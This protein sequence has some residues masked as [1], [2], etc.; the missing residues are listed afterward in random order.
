M[1]LVFIGPPGA[2]KGTQAQRLTA[3][4]AIPHVSTGDMLREARSQQTPLGQLAEK[5][6]S[7][8]EL[9]PDDVIIQLVRER[10]SRPDC[11]RGVL[12]D[13]FPRTLAQAQGL[14]ADLAQTGTPIDR[15]I[16]LAASDDELFRRLTSRGRADDNPDV[17]RQRLASYHRDTRPL[18]DYYRD[19]GILRTVD[20]L[21]TFDEVFA[22]IKSV[23]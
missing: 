23:L 7:R 3:A 4:L 1:R 18:L 15:A 12:L 21:G 6:M 10:L 22:R 16:E 2:G 19:Q 20:G 14:D 13:G 11:G 9:V 17:I 5:Y 8:G